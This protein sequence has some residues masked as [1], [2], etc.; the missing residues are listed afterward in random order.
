MSFNCD[1]KSAWLSSAHHLTKANIQ[2][3]FN[4]NPSRGKGDGVDIK[5]KAQL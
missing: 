2:P 4:E 5:F 3:K 1:L